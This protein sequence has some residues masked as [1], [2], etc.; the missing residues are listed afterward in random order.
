MAVPE[1]HSPRRSGA[2]PIGTYVG[3]SRD[4]NPLEVKTVNGPTNTLKTSNRKMT[5][6]VEATRSEFASI[7]HAVARQPALLDRLHVDAYGAIAVPLKQVAWRID[8]R[9]AQYAGDHGAATR[10]SSRRR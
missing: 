2:R 7:L 8:T 4:A 10:A 6:C 9:H 5:K 3:R 1:E